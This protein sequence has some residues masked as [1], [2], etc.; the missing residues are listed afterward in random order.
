MGVNKQ[1]AR[2]NKQPET[3]RTGWRGPDLHGGSC[4]VG[5]EGSLRF[6]E[7]RSRSGVPSQRD[8]TP[9]GVGGFCV[10]AGFTGGGKIMESQGSGFDITY[11]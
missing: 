3:E 5:Q 8:V 11:K 7:M 1:Q 4:I 2:C 6:R 9:A 10:R